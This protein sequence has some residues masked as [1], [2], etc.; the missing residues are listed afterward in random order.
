M[1][2]NISTINIDG[3]IYTTRPYGT[4][5]TTSGTQEKKVVCD[6]FYL[7]NSAVLLVKFTN[8]NTASNPT[9]V[10][11]YGKD[12]K[13]AAKPIYYNGVAVTNVTSWSSNSIV[14]LYYDGTNW[15]IISMNIPAAVNTTT[16]G[17]VSTT[18]QTFGGAKTFSS[19]STHSEGLSVPANKNIEVGSA[20]IKYNST[21]GCLEISC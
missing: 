7:A 12:K 11:E 20:Y 3:S 18:A 4:C 16:Q 13:T 21:T 10:V 1:A 9:L 17:I 5:E 15:N 14:E 19:K 2:K 6:D 8:G